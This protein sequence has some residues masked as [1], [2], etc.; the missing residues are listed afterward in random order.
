VLTASPIS[1][2]VAVTVNSFVW[3][4]APGQG[5]LVDSVTVENPTQNA[6]SMSNL[7]DLTSGLSTDLAFVVNASNAATLGYSSYCNLDPAYPPA[8][9]P[10][11][12]GQGLTV[13]SGTANR[14]NQTAGILQPGARVQISLSYGPVMSDVLPAV[15][16]VYFHAGSSMAVDLTRGA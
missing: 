15:V 2:T 16:S 1:F 9:C 13:D 3:S 5:F 12:F 6:E 7:A 10:I 11:S 14:A 4:A 8:L